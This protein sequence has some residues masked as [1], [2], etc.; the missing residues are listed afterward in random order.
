MLGA[1]VGA[2]AAVAMA[3]AVAAAAAAVAVL[4]LLGAAVVQVQ[5]FLVASVACTRNSFLSTEVS[6]VRTCSQ[7]VVLGSLPCAFGC[8]V[9]RYARKECEPFCYY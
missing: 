6:F 9:W 4:L 7:T 8:H 3:L 1:A 2:V 5:Q